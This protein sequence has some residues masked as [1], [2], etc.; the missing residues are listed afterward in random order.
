MVV[1]EG[2]R[3]AGVVVGIVGAAIEVEP[4]DLVAEELVGETVGEAMAVA[5]MAAVAK[6][7]EDKEV[8]RAAATRAVALA[9]VVKVVEALMVAAPGS[10]L[11]GCASRRFQLKGT[12]VCAAA[13]HLQPL[14]Q[15]P[16][17]G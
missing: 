8:E 16:R 13:R 14:C 15:D 11:D 12:G 2:A 6:E 3:V 1:R 10:P 4:V 7:E 5:E 17:V 9:A